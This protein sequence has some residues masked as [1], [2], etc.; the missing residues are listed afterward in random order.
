MTE[1]ETRPQGA[2][3]GAVSKPATEEGVKA[4]TIEPTK[5]PL[6]PNPESEWVAFGKGA[7]DATATF[8]VAAMTPM[9]NGEHPPL[10]QVSLFRETKEQNLTIPDAA[11]EAFRLKTAE[12][13]IGKR[14]QKAEK[15]LLRQVGAPAK[16]A[17]VE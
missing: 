3:T 6:P 15:P 16:L 14:E 4:A 7:V 17:T 9:Q 5:P 1:G 13:I 8:A 11:R 10:K 2:E 12:Q